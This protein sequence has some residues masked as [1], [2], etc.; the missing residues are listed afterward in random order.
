[1]GFYLC[2]VAFFTRLPR[3][4]VLSQ[5]DEPMVLWFST[6]WHV[7]APRGGGFHGL[8]KVGEYKGGGDFRGGI[9]SW[10][11]FVFKEGGKIQGC[12]QCSAGI[13]KD[14]ETPAPRFSPAKS[15]PY[16]ILHPPCKAVLD[17]Q[18]S[19]F[20]CNPHV[21]GDVVIGEDVV[22]P[23]PARDAFGSLLRTLCICGT[24]SKAWQQQLPVTY[25]PPS[26]SP[27]V[28]P[29]PAPRRLPAPGRLLPQGDWSP[30]AP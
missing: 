10:E 27:T 22:H 19:F 25:E 30:G 13:P 16:K 6:T 3:S 21:R 14:G 15:S 20:G 12:R 7:L 28:L 9:L 2:C 23:K 1:M 24:V 29:H 5:H 11:I 8:G 26:I 18:S 17:Y 4:T